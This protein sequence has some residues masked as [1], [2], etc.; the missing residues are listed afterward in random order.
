MG[1]LF[2]IVAVALAVGAVVFGVAVLVTGGE[3]GLAP[4]EP[5][6]RAVPLPTDRPLAEEDIAGARF[7]V[8]L[9]GYRMVQVDQAMRRAAYDIGYKDELINVLE[10]EIA[11]L[12]GGRIE[13]AE[14]LRRA[15]EAS[16]VGSARA[17]APEDELPEPEAL[18]ELDELTRPPEPY[19]GPEP[20]DP[21]DGG[22]PTDRDPRDSDPT[23][24]GDPT[25]GA[26]SGADPADP[27]PVDETA[28]GEPAG[29]QQTEAQ[30]AR[31]HARTD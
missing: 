12:R 19:R 30:Q 13:D 11:A 15:R 26:R 14:V 5:D 2:L 6:G 7:D 10:A 1:Q 8:S 3:A 17:A 23:D 20:D 4:A 21:T 16:L 27:E 31:A 29:G 28:G 18:F 24:G 9:R 25:D 22:D